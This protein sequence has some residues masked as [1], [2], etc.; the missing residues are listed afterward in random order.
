MKITNKTHYMKNFSKTKVGDIIEY[1]GE[2]Y[3]VI[4][5]VDSINCIHLMTG[6]GDYLY[7]KTEV[8]VY[9]DTELIIKG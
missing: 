4:E 6:E 1:E 3:I 5:A 9:E 8:R 7:P 2:Y